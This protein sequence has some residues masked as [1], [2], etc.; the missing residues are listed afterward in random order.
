MT[1][2]ENV[3]YPLRSRR[4]PR[5]EIGDRVDHALGLVGIAELREQHPS[6][7]SGGQQQRVALA[8]ALVAN[9]QLVLFDEPLSNVDARVREQLRYEMAEMQARIGFAAVYVTHDQVEA[10]SL[11]HHVAVMRAG[12]VQQ[13]GTPFEVYDAPR[14]PYVAAF[15]GTSNM[16]DG[17]VT[18][19]ANDHVV[20]DSAV[21][22]V[23]ATPTITLAVGDAVSLAFRPERG[24]FDVTGGGPN[25]VPAVVSSSMFIGAYT[26]YVLSV[27]VASIKLTSS[28]RRHLPN[29]SS[30]FLSVPATDLLAMS[31]DGAPSS[32]G[33]GTAR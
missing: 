10:M 5:G 9:D 18:G 12:G 4:E 25:S 3:A 29:G 22:P 32:V 2:F 13:F 16:I 24:R 6:Q 31:A 11:A 26:E 17:T 7:M 20:V 8:R 33:T 27:G 14:T 21:G 30:G 28:E 23:R 19:V 15:V 1:A